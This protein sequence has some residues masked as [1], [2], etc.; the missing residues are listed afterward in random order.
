[1]SKNKSIGLDVKQIGDLIKSLNTLSKT[2]EKMPNELVNE[3][4][5]LGL[6]KLNEKYSQRKQDENI[7]DINTFIKTSENRCDILS[8]GKDV[9]YEEFG[10]GDKGE[11]DPHPDIKSSYH[12]NKYNSGKYIRSSDNLSDEKAE[13]EG[14]TKPGKYWTYKKDGDIKYTQGVPSGKEMFETSKYLKET[15]PDVL[16]KK[17]SDVLSK[18]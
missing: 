5:A 16:K 18:V 1:M 9:V 10:T 11:A 8:Q 13:E 17:R 12:L 6:E 15:I 14:I 4:G 2:L 3:L 7:T